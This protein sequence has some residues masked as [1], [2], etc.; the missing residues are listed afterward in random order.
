MDPLAGYISTSSPTQP[1]IKELFGVP[2]A[3]T[4]PINVPTTIKISQTKSEPINITGEIVGIASP[5]T[6][7]IY[8]IPNNST[9]VITNIIVTGVAFGTILELHYVRV[10]A[11]GIGDFIVF[12][13]RLSTTNDLSP[14]NIPFPNGLFLDSNLVSNIYLTT[15]RANYGMRAQIVGYLII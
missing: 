15:D 11:T 7:I 8:T 9:F 4:E 13:P 6:S 5:T 3:V 2:T 14:I 1:Q 12:Y 10:G